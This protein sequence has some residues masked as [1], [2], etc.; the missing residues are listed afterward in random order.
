MCGPVDAPAGSTRPK[1][2]STRPKADSACDEAEGPPQNAQRRLDG[3]GMEHALEQ[4]GLLLH[5]R[6]PLRTPRGLL[7]VCRRVLVGLGW[8]DPLR[9]PW[10]HDGGLRH[11]RIGLCLAG[12]VGHG[13]SLTGRGGQGA[14]HEPVTG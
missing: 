9:A 8:L 14:D 12:L 6:S 10:H 7:L 1:A 11:L 3:I 13:Q 2:G 5:T 4:S